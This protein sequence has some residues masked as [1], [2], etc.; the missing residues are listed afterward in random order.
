M[1]V[2]ANR[3]WPLTALL[4][5]ATTT[6]LAGGAGWPAD[7]GIHPHP[8]GEFGIDCFSPQ[9][10]C[11]AQVTRR[12][13]G[14]P[15]EEPEDPPEDP[16]AIPHPARDLPRTSVP[17]P[18]RWRIMESL[19]LEER[20]W[21]P[22][23]Q[24]TLKADK[25]VHGDWFFNINLISDTI[26]EPRSVPTPV[27]IQTSDRPDQI[28]VFG[29]NDQLILVQNAIVG[30]VYYQGDTVFRPPDYEFRLTLAFNYNRV[31]ADER[32]FL[33]ID[34]D[35]GTVRRDEFIGVQELFADKHLRNIGERY[36]FDSVRVGIQPFNADFRG[37]LFQDFQLGIRFFGNRDNNFWQYN[38]AW[39][40]RLEKDTNSGLNDLGKRLRD[41]D[42]FI[43]NLYR[44][45]WP[46]KGFFSQGV[47][48]Y[49]RNRE[50]DFHFDKNGF[51]VRPAS[52]GFELPRKY[53]VVYLGYNGD[54][55][56]G[57]LNLTASAYYA[58]GKER[59]GV[60]SGRNSDIR[61]GFAAFEAGMDFSWIRLRFSG[62]YA[63]GDRDPFDGRSTGFDAIFENP[64]FAGADTSYW[65]RQNV[66]LVGG[67]G[68]ALAGRNGVLNSLRPS[69]EQG[70]SNFTNPGIRLIGIGTDLDLTPEFR[71]SG[72]LNGL[73]FDHTSSV[74]A[75]RNQGDIGRS[76]GLDAS[77][78]TIYRP[79]ATQNIVL[80]G[81]VAGLIPGSGFRQ[82][83]GSGVQYSVLFNLIFAY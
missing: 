50:T 15:V 11:L 69:K 26:I 63:S 20:W 81:S 34:P 82:L 49:N 72:N 56:F 22:Y 23:N 67:G 79:F 10:V 71:I 59:P 2:P 41:D 73:W 57:R 62:L 64:V 38:L 36:D 48:A 78:A 43:A 54:G 76:I 3:R 55:H 32:R 17:V 75:A 53:D 18:D 35:R 65:I 8:G 19:G 30:L 46:V 74:E 29:G 1:S 6:A 33:F 44:Q 28:D 52:L 47:I 39:F 60:F 61:A 4:A 68:V 51:L 42:V 27:G 31:K 77:V 80:R 83:F 37:F 21:D 58:V 13:P 45:D 16:D 5:A 12:R 7:P 40:R 66:P 14:R 24:N 70:Q 25:P 9:A